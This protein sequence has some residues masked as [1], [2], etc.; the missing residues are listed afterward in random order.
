V[1][2]QEGANAELESTLAKLRYVMVLTH[3]YCGTVVFVSGA[4]MMLEA[5]LVSFLSI[6]GMILQVTNITSILQYLFIQFSNNDQMTTAYW[7]FAFWLN[8]EVCVFVAGILGCT[9]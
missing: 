8:T 1:E 2:P 3:F 6:I 9:I 5:Q 7:E 4:A